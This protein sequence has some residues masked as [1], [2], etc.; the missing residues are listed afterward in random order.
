MLAELYQYALSH[1]LTAQPGFKPKRPKAYLML[2][3]SGEYVGIELRDKAAPP[4]MAPD[5]G[6]MANGTRYCNILIEKAC[7]PLG[8]IIDPVKDKNIPTKREF[9]LSAL[10]SGTADE[11]YFGVLAGAL[12]N[13]SLIHIYCCVNPFARCFG[14]VM[15]QLAFQH[16]RQRGS[17]LSEFHCVS[18]FL[19][20]DLGLSAL[21][22]IVSAFNR[23]IRR[24]VKFKLPFFINSSISN[25]MQKKGRSLR[26]DNKKSP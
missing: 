24:K 4:V 3:S 10:E 15:V 7:I 6:A 8:I 5:I 1:E 14:G 16:C 21:C 9:Y 13:L 22:V 17:R 26:K 23:N 2:T 11:P 25:L 18:H 20:S 19:S 12:Q